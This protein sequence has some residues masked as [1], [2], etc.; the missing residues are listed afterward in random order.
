VGAENL[1]HQ[2]TLVDYTSGAVAP[3]DPELA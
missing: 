1:C 3:L 2:A